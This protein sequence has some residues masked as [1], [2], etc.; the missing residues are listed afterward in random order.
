MMA[1]N[2]R[3]PQ[4]PYG[5]PG[6][7][8]PPPQQYAAPQ[9]AYGQQA[10]GAPPQQ[11]AYSQ[12]GYAPPGQQPYAQPGYA[13]SQSPHQSAPQGAPP[14]ID[15]RIASFFT[16]IDTDRSGFLDAK[17]LQ[18]A[19][20]MGNLNFGLTDIDQMVRA[21]DV[22]GSRNLNIQE[23]C[24]LHEF[25]G[26]VTLSFNYFDSN[27]SQ[28]LNLDSVVKALQHAGFTMD[29]P[30][31]QAMFKKHDPNNSNTLSLDEFIRLCLF[32]QSCVR[33]FGAFDAQRTGRVTLDFNQFVYA[34]SHIS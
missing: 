15:P 28:A 18:K 33:T 30:V 2:A 9:Q 34:A 24:K 11:Q 7:G 1:Y 5:Q 4:Q 20:A 32:L 6:Y 23:F 26:S 16:A 10:Y 22:K 31:V 3:P 25:L 27:K 14:G 21:F 12:P 19:L 29:P 17:E 13:P 8:A